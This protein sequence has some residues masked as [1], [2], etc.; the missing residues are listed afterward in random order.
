MKYSQYKYN[1][2]LNASHSIYI[3]GL[4]GERHPHTWEISLYVVNYKDTF[5]MF[6]QVEKTIEDYLMQFQEK[7]INDCPVFH[8]INPTL[9]NIAH[10]FMNELQ[11]LL[12]PLNWIIFT[13]EISETPS[14]SYII[15][16]VENNVIRQV[17]KKNIAEEILLRSRNTSH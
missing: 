16:N 7:Y 13:M 14:R 11:T 8:T 12:H 4:Q 2:Y 10:C 17:E 9:E 1:F 3:D 5:V 15:S 6:N